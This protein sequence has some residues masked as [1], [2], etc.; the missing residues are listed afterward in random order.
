MEGGKIIGQ[1][2]FGCVY[3]PSLLCDDG[4]NL[5]RE[6]NKITKIFKSK[7]SAIKERKE[8]KIIDKIDP[9]FKFHLP[10]PT[11]CNKLKKPDI[12]HDNELKDCSYIKDYTKYSALNFEYGGLW[13]IEFISQYIHK[14]STMIEREN[15]FINFYNS[16]GNLFDGL[17][18]LGK[19]NY[20]HFDIKPFN[21]LVKK[22]GNDLRFNL[23]DFGVSHTI[24]H[25]TNQQI[26]GMWNYSFDSYI[27]SMPM[28]FLNLHFTTILSSYE[29]FER[30][31]NQYI[32][33]TNKDSIISIIN[34][35]D[36]NIHALITKFLPEIYEDYK[37]IFGDKIKLKYNNKPEYK[38]MLEAN[39]KFKTEKMDV[40]K[41]MDVFGMGITLIMCWHAIFGEKFKF[42]NPETILGQFKNKKIMNYIIDA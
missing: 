33:D 2:G 11:I 7:A 28:L 25:F 35:T 40:I 12:E 3:K 23:I 21:V 20:T 17:V 27:L 18:A 42:K 30:Y 38:D 32:S 37:I 16:M 39:N 19:N 4:K 34:H 26:P 1:G 29:S 22:Q 14:D 10:S 24:E 5:P 31:M 41:K 6:S 8:H 9:K 15:F 36:V 13:L